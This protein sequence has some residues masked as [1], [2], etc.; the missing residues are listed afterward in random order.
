MA[1]IVAFGLEPVRPIVFCCQERMAGLVT[2][3]AETIMD[4]VR[5]VGV[6][7]EKL[8]S[9]M[10]VSTGT[11]ISRCSWHA[12]VTPIPITVA[13]TAQPSA[14]RR[15]VILPGMSQPPAC[16]T[17]CAMNSAAVYSTACFCRDDG[18]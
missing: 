12:E 4:S 14:I 2:G 11:P 9:A 10:L 13:A 7:S 5:K 18:Y 15:M 6:G 8:T 16:P 17:V 3:T 1:L